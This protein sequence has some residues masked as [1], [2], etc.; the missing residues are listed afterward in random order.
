M[1]RAMS[2]PPRE[3]LLFQPLCTIDTLTWS[4]T[5]FHTVPSSA[6][7]I[8]CGAR[9]HSQ[10]PSTPAPTPTPACVWVHRRLR[11]TVSTPAP[12]VPHQEGYR[13]GLPTIGCILPSQSGAA[14]FPECSDIPVARQTRS[15]LPNS[16]LVST[17]GIWKLAGIWSLLWA[18]RSPVGLQGSHTHT[19]E[20]AGLSLLPSCG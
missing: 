2:K 18:T 6:V 19:G 17:R 11:T 5:R 14:S 16:P 12:T 9:D 15:L 10:I 8:L 7:P 1:E 4:Q 3:G 20:Q 13:L